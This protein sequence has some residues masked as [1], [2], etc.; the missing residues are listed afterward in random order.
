MS[1]RMKRTRILTHRIPTVLERIPLSPQVAQDSCSHILRLQRYPLTI[2]QPPL[3]I[4]QLISRRHQPRPL[5]LSLREGR[6]L[7][8]VVHLDS[9]VLRSH[10]REP[11]QII[12]VGT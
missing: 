4:R 9:D 8:A 5:R 7:G 3:S 6:R 2:L 12:P 1:K 11:E 10:C